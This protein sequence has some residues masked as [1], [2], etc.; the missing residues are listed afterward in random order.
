M[1][2]KSK[3]FNRDSNLQEIYL[4]LKSIQSKID[5]IFLTQKML[6][7][8]TVFTPEHLAQWHLSDISALRAA[9][10]SSEFVQLNLN[11]A[12]IYPNKFEL[13]SDVGGKAL[14]E[15]EILEFGVGSGE[16]LHHFSKTFP[17]RSIYGFDSF[18]G[19]PENW[20][21]GFP[22]GTFSDVVVPTERNNINLIKGLF[23]DTLEDFLAK[24][25]L[26]IAIVHCDADLY[27]STKFV[28]EKLST[29]IQN[30]TIIFFDEYFNYP[31]WEQHEHKALQEWLTETGYSVKFL[32]Y[33]PSHEQVAL[34]VFLPTF[35]DSNAQSN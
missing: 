15:G 8:R 33:V 9:W 32:G 27:S 16:T 5:D 28:L 13:I 11:E 6:Y 31:G 1:K 2:W 34:Q 25:D 12:M 23:Q 26:K 7:P 17:N 22:E 14:S 29:K 35:E 24:T 30:G 18:D 19:L 3:F 10:T 4:E 21:S 20:R